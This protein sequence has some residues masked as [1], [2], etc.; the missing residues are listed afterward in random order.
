[1]TQ[2][3]GQFSPMWPINRRQLL[4]VLEKASVHKVLIVGW[5]PSSSLR[6]K[7]VEETSLEWNTIRQ[8]KDS[9]L[10]VRTH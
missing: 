8:I 9:F 2:S 7:G 1:M 5:E 10:A 3:F 6:D 4:C